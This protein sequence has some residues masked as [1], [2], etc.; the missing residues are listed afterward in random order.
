MAREKK[1]LFST[2]PEHIITQLENICDGKIISATETYGGLSASAGFV[3]NMQDGRR[4]FAKG[5]HPL[6]TSHGAANLLQ[7][8][9]AYHSVPLLHDIAPRLIGSVT[10][11]AEE[12]WLLG[13]WEYISPQQGSIPRIRHLFE[14]LQTA[15]LPSLPTAAAHNYIGFFFRDEKKWLRLRD[16]EKVRDKFLALFTDRK[17][18]KHWLAESLPALCKLQAQA[19]D[20]CTADALL[21]GDL[22]LDN[23]I[24]GTDHDYII[25]WPNA[26]LGPRVFDRCFLGANL[27]GLGLAQ[28]EEWVGSDAAAPVMAAAMAGYFADQAYRTPP[29]AMPRLRWMQK[30]MLLALLK[31]LGRQGIIESPPEMAR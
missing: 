5:T 20:I 6:E 28:V 13:V 30:C 4:F 15:P 18:V 31:Y 2:V 26:C 12:G 7:E 14:K 21:H 19:A 10:D 24:F 25:D 23:F 1:P 11:N 9:A 8:I 29:D 17:L 27:E 22:R 3:L 16:E